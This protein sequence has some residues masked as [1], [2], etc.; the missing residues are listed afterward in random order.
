MGGNNVKDLDTTAICYDASESEANDLCGLNATESFVEQKEITKINVQ[1][2]QSF[3][4]QSMCNKISDL[5]EESEI[6]VKKNIHSSALAKNS[7]QSITE[8]IGNSKSCCFCKGDH[9]SPFCT[10]YPTIKAKMDRAKQL[11]LCLKC[12]QEGHQTTQCRTRL[13]PCYFCGDIHNLAFHDLCGYK[14]ASRS[15]NVEIS[16]LEQAKKIE[17]NFQT[18]RLSTPQPIDGRAASN[19]SKKQLEESGYCAKPIGGYSHSFIIK[20]EKPKSCSFCQGDHKSIFCTKYYTAQARMDRAEQ[21]KLCLGCLQMGHQKTQC[22][23]ELKP[24]YYC[25]IKHNSA[26]Y[27]FLVYKAENEIDN[28]EIYPLKEMK[29]IESNFQTIRPSAPRRLNGRAARNKAKTQF[30]ENAYCSKPT[31][32]CSHPFCDGDHE[33][34]LLSI[35]TT[36]LTRNHQAQRLELCKN[37]LQGNQHRQCV[38]K[39]FHPVLYD[40]GSETLQFL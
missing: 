9:K 17:S 40:E 14:A 24:C 10:A 3:Y 25:G 36:A 34:D 12:L 2:P 6:H 26:Y 13:N 35:Y 16:P 33:S 37:C 32:D 19:R 11:K 27:D 38:K 22:G 4:S 18:I 15:D 21:L 8:K 28:I 30:E 23:L 39:Q 1:T 7:S 5:T 29:E 20:T 31:K